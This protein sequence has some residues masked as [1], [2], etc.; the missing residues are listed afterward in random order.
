MMFQE[1]FDFF[2]MHFLVSKGQTRNTSPYL[3]QRSLYGEKRMIEGA[4]GGRAKRHVKH[5]NPCSNK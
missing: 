4:F 2:S 3:E 5:H 1:K